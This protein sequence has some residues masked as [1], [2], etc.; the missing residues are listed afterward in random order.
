MRT[1]LQD[2]ISKPRKIFDLAANASTD[3]TPV[4]YAQASKSSHWRK[5]M[6]TEFLALQQQGTWSLVPH[7]DQKPILGCK[8]TFKTKLLPNGQIDRHKA[9]LVALGCSQEYGINYTETFSPVAKMVTIR[10]L[11]TVALHHKWTVTQLDVSNAFLH[12]ELHDEV[13]MRQPTGFVDT[14]FPNHVCR[15]HKSIYGLKQ[16]PRQWFQ[17]FT[18]FLKTLGFVF[19]KADPSLLLYTKDKTN[20]Y[21]LVY[22]DDI[23][24]TGNNKEHIQLIL[25][26]LHDRFRLKELGNASLF[27]GIQILPTSSGYFLSQQHYALELIKNA[28]FFSCKPCS[29][30]AGTKRSIKHDKDALHS[31]PHSYRKLAGSLQYLSITRP[32]IAFATNAYVNICINQG[33]A[34]TKISRGCSDTCKERLTTDFPFAMVHFSYAVTPTLTGPRIQTTVSPFLDTARSSAQLSSLGQLK[35]KR[36]WRNPPPKPNTGHCPQPLRTFSGQD[37]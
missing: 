5:A 20:I 34:I 30:P 14:Q 23:L 1:R 29:T 13:Y 31:D 36:R 37:A 27:L 17:Q 15:L 4:S 16:S 6:S 24:I 8:W 2:G 28:G 26:S 9:R 10:M 32:D 18:D 12:G 11:L 19:S 22:I 35:S 33:T 3:D 7:P 21:I 25:R